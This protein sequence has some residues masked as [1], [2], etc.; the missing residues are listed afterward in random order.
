M[1]PYSKKK[2][3]S[4]ICPMCTQPKAT[5][6]EYEYKKGHE[7]DMRC[8]RCGYYFL[9]TEVGVICATKDPTKL[10]KIED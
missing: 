10:S 5:L 6:R 3:H 2:Y 8:P 7:Y 9:F 4:K 1:K